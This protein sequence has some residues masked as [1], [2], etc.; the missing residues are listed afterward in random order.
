MHRNSK[1]NHFNVFLLLYTYQILRNNEKIRKEPKKGEG[2]AN[3]YANRTGIYT[4]GVFVCLNYL[5]S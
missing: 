3:D 1:R 2:T 5:I 4:A